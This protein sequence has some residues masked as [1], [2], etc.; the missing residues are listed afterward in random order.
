MKFFRDIDGNPRVDSG[1][2]GEVLGSFLSEDIQDS[3]ASCREILTVIEM[4]LG[5]ELAA[6]RRVG[7]AHVLS[8]SRDEAVIESL[9]ET[10]AKPLRLNLE[11]FRKSVEGWLGFLNRPRS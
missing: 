1:L 7:N 11:V 9:F 5:G 3:P 4:V 10:E 8:L 2:S 6:W